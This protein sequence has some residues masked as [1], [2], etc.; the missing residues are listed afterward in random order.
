MNTFPLVG[1]ISPF[2]HFNKVD[3]P[4][5]VGP[6]IANN[7]LEGTATFIVLRAV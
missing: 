4:Q 2:K 3:F 5:P 6:I 1:L 7:D